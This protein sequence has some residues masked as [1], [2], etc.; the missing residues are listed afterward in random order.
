MQRTQKKWGCLLLAGILLL[1][2]FAGC[3]PKAEE[4]L[5][6]GIVSGTVSPD[7]IAIVRGENKL[8][9]TTSEA[10]F[11][12]EIGEHLDAVIVNYGWGECNPSDITR[13]DDH[14]L[15]ISFQ[16]EAAADD[17]D[18]ENI[19]YTGYLMVSGE[20]S[21]E[22]T[23][24]SASFP[25]AMPVLT[26]LGTA[27]R[28]ASS[29]NLEL[30]LENARLAD[31][32]Q[33]GDI[34]LSK[35]FE[36]MEVANIQRQSET[37]LAL[38]LNGEMKSEG[39]D[40]VPYM[41][42]GLAIKPQ[43]TNAAVRAYGEVPLVT[44]TAYLAGTPAFT[45]SA[46]LRVSAAAENCQ[47]SQVPASSQITLSG[48]F[49]GA[50]VKKVEKCTKNPD[51]M[52]VYIA[53]SQKDCEGVGS[54]V[55]ASE[56]TNAGK[57][58]GV[59]V[60]FDNI[61]FYAGVKSLEKTAEKVTLTISAAS[62]GL[63]FNRKLT[64]EDLTPAGDF[65]QAKVENVLQG[66]DN[67]LEIT[68][69]FST[70][71]FDAVDGY[72]GIILVPIESLESKLGNLEDMDAVISV[73]S[74]KEEEAAAVASGSSQKTGNEIQLLS[75]GET[76]LLA[77]DG[78]AAANAL[79]GFVKDGLLSMAKAGLGKVGE[80]VSGKLLSW[81]GFES[82]E[83]QINKKLDEIIGQLNSLTD[84]INNIEQS[85]NKLIDAVETSA[86]K[87]QM[88][89]IQASVLKLKS[90]VSGYQAA[91]GEVSKLEAGSEEYKKEMKILADKINNTN[92]LDFHGET[93]ALGEKILSDAAGTA[94]GALKAHYDRITTKNNWEQQTYD[95]RERFYLYSVGTYLQSAML[96]SIA[97]GYVADTLDSAV[98]RSEAQNNLKELKAQIARVSSMAEKYQVKRL[99][100][101]YNRNL[102]TGI[103][104]ST[105]VEKVTY[106]ANNRLVSN[107]DAYRLIQQKLLDDT[108]KGKYT[109]LAGSGAFTLSESLGFLTE[110][111]A[112]DIMKY[113]S[114]GSLV[115]ELKSAGFSIPSGCPDSVMLRDIRIV[116][117]GI[118][119]GTS[120]TRSEIAVYYKTFVKS[121]SETLF[122]NMAFAVHKFV[123]KPDSR[124]TDPDINKAT[125]YRES[126]W[127]T[128]SMEVA[129]VKQVKESKDLYVN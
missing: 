23:A 88:R 94:D 128:G 49:A 76:T 100:S 51:T 33:K 34:E 6:T 106:D 112:Q 117:N 18:R 57:P 9:L 52:D 111:Q 79:C 71:V 116:K 30:E 17:M 67:S 80:I 5:E 7:S 101:D 31:E 60:N 27:A 45:D 77:L 108:P 121:T 96:D 107:A 15:E 98:E 92:G 29:I 13:R 104:L 10:E 99:K 95:E 82:S 129:S 11:S 86:F 109:S 85:I 22:G 4:N 69:T 19:G 119:T 120:A 126:S 89:D 50:T 59:D 38:T 87:E 14:T 127:F 62:H 103:I 72:E 20:Y 58:V 63:Q 64:P 35:A 102:R 39:E 75:A 61:G 53:V 65:E 1:S 122:S 40:L 110:K 118:R 83:E 91:L 44:A 54:I 21:Q 8:T 32:V 12:K 105:K 124:D 3:A 93:Y 68:L 123:W 37:R 28:D 78:D 73:G 114:K 42:G 25:I 97:L 47:W 90:R 81:L 36:G 2:C 43:A 26:A 66:E 84:R 16:A 24:V 74:F 113:S 55:F 125:K 70:S 115:E 41:E 56:A 48:A 46:T